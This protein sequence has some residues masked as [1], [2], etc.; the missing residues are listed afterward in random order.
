MTKEAD[1]EAMWKRFG[2]AAL[3][4]TISLQK[5]VTIRSAME[6]Q[7][8]VVQYISTSFARILVVF[9]AEED[10]LREDGH[11]ESF[12]TGKWAMVG[13][14]DSAYAFSDSVFC[15]GGSSLWI[16]QDF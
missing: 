16:F 11:F 15:L 8:T 14:I 7:Y 12:K 1:F 3:F 10:L 4:S 6:H 9:T 5:R 13:L 2:K